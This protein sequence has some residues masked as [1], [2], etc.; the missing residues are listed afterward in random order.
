MQITLYIYNILTHFSLPCSSLSHL[1]R[2]VPS[3]KK[4]KKKVSEI[5]RAEKPDW[6]EL[7][8][9]HVVYEKQVPSD[10][11]ERTR[12]PVSGSSAY[13]LLLCS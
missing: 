5:Q 13:L 9:I 6:L 10:A 1:Q 7:T 4:K 11:Q 2:Q 12:S 3:S 8:L